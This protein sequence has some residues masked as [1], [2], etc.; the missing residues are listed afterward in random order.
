MERGIEALEKSTN[1]IWRKRYKGADQKHFSRVVQ[2]MPAIEGGTTN[3]RNLQEVI[4]ELA[5]G[6]V[7]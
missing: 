5:R 7:C 6:F 1:K 4:D 3:G 2:L